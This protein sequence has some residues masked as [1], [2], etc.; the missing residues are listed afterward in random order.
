[1]G[2]TSISFDKMKVIK[3]LMTL[4]IA[5]SVVICTGCR[6]FRDIFAEYANLLIYN[7][8]SSNICYFCPSVPEMINN[9]VLCTYPDTTICFEK[10]YGYLAFIEPGEIRTAH[11][12]ARY[13][14]DWFYYFPNDTISVFLFDGKTVE[15]VPWETVV[16][17]YL[18]LQRYDLSIE[19]MKKLDRT[20]HYPPTPEMRD[21]HMWPPYEEAV[22]MRQ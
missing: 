8:S 14:E 11:G 2:K 20:I 10:P 9:Q 17:E 19:D 5:V 7:D 21:I 15:T 16:K 4:I 18:V 22:K 6:E 12:Q 1:M 3:K 13:L